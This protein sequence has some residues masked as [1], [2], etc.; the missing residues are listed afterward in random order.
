MVFPL[1][2]FS[3]KWFVLSESDGDGIFLMRDLLVKQRRS[4]GRVRHFCLFVCERLS[5]VHGCPIPPPLYV[6]VQNIP[7]IDLYSAHSNH[8]AHFP[9]K[10]KAEVPG[11]CIQMPFTEHDRQPLPTQKLCPA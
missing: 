10:M 5:V 1:T 8:S 11:K 7:F 6:A 9:E 3:L 2:S 4:L